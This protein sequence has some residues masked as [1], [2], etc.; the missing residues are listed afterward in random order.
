[1]FA[2]VVNLIA[3]GLRSIDLLSAAPAHQRG[4]YAGY[5]PYRAKRYLGQRAVDETPFGKPGTT[6][7][8]RI[9]AVQR[10]QRRAKALR[11]TGDDHDHKM[12]I[13]LL[14]RCGR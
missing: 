1:M 14:R 6:S 7:E 10:Y 3:N 11:Q 5:K 9:R 12:A 4:R 2:R 13:K 8:L